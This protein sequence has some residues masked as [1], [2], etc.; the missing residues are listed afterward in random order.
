M[1]RMTKAQALAEFREIYAPAV[2][3]R[4]GRGDAIAMREEWN[5]YTDSLHRDRQITDWQVNNWTNPF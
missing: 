4:Y 1:A 3:A 2:R 5:N